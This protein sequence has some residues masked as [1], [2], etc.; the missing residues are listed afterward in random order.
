[1]LVAATVTSGCH[2]SD[3]AS[4]SGSGSNTS[5]TNGA[6]GNRHG[7]EA[8]SLAPSGLTIYTFLSCSRPWLMLSEQ[9]YSTS[10][11]SFG[12]W[13]HNLCGDLCHSALFRSVARLA[14]VSLLYTVQQT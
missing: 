1:M 5:L 11:H 2:T 3:V 12:L 13:L 4:A 7:Y 6:L 9:Y 8:L 10:E 14:G